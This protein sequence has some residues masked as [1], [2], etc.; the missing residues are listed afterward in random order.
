[1]LEQFE[2]SD[3]SLSVHTVIGVDGKP[4]ICKEGCVG[5][6]GIHS[7]EVMTLGSKL[8][9]DHKQLLGKCNVILV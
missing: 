8:G 3:Q 5:F 6:G 1:M 9:T 7:S 2:L 4:F